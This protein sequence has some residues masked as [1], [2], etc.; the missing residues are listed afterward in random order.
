[1]K[2]TEKSI[3]K[4]FAPTRRCYA[5]AQIEAVSDA[6]SIFRKAISK[7]EPVASSNWGKLETQIAVLVLSEVTFAISHVFGL[8]EQEAQQLASVMDVLGLTV[9]GVKAAMVDEDGVP[10][11]FDLERLKLVLKELRTIEVQNE[12]LAA[13]HAKHEARRATKKDGC[14]A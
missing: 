10:E 3:K 7:L 12:K 8:S 2:Y 6:E 14:P 9:A 5:A 11:T 4:A 13:K 1:M